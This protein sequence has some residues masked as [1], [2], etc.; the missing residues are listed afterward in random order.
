[1]EVSLKHYRIKEKSKNKSRGFDNGK[2]LKC[3]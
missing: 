2:T 1:M 3:D